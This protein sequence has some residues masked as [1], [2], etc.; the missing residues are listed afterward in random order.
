MP[1]NKFQD[2]DGY[3][4]IDKTVEAFIRQGEERQA[5]ARLPRAER[6]AKIKEHRHNDERRGQRA[7]YDLPTEI[8]DQIKRLADQ[9]KTSA[10]QITAL[11]LALFIDRIEHDPEFLQGYLVLLDKPNPRY[12]RQVVL[13]VSRLAGK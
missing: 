1:K 9:H 2:E 8:I 13:P 5:T 12:E 7:T 4:A 3:L 6:K 11:A 10:S